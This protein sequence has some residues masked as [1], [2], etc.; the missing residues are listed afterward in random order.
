MVFNP[1][2]APTYS[3]WVKGKVERPIDYLRERFWRGYAY[4][5]LQNANEDVV[6]WLNETANKRVHGTHHHPINERWEQETAFLGKLP[7]VEYDTSLKT[8]RKVYK[9]CQLSYN[10]SRYVV[11]YHAV[12]KTVMLKIKGTLI[13]IY[14]NDAEDHGLTPVGIYSLLSPPLVSVVFKLFYT[15]SGPNFK[16]LIWTRMEVYSFKNRLQI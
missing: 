7:P 6:A 2:P 8:F 3:P 14:Q 5:S 10:G 4:R 9:D 11:P 13:R 15:K 1:D 16:N 12:G